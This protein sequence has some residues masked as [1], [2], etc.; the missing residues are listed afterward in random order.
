M[1]Y[2]ERRLFPSMR[3]DLGVHQKSNEFGIAACVLARTT[4]N[5]LWIVLWESSLSPA[6]SS[7]V[8]PSTRPWATLASAG[9]KSNDP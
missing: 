4:L 9:L 2:A 8:R 5:C 3:L 7:S 6:I 1:T